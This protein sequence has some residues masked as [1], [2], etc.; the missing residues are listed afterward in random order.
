MKKLRSRRGMTF[1][2]TLVALA[3]VALIGAVL[4]AGITTAVRIYRNA[5]DVSEAQTLCASLLT[6]LEDE[7]RFARGVHEEDGAVVFDST[8]FG[9]R[10]HI[11]T[12][13]AGQVRIGDFA[14]LSR[15]AYTRG[16]Q[17]W[18]STACDGQTVTLTV[19]VGRGDSVLTSQT[20][21]LRP[22]NI[23]GNSE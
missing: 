17:A 19:S 10:V 13:E 4:A 21:T 12:D 5:A 23:V 11:E 6:S 22:L 7:L 14:V 2:E 18:V 15:E 8:S 9:T 16:L 3:I 20:V 1:A